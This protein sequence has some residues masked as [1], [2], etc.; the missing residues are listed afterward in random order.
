MA[1]EALTRIAALYQVEAAARDLTAE[2]RKAY[3][4]EH[5]APLLQSLKAWLDQLRPAV[6]GA[7]GTAKAIDYTLRRWSALTR[8]LEDGRDPINNNRIENAIRPIALGRKNWLFA[9][10]ERAGQ[11]AAAI[12]SLLAT[13]KANSHDPHAWLTDLLTRLPA[14][15]D[16]D[17]GTLLPISWQPVA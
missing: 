15:L 10:S 13:A 9:G 12:M 4:Q 16:R 2:D 1:Q 5:A 7:S 6:P 14:T 11:R 8:Y 17:L 3:R